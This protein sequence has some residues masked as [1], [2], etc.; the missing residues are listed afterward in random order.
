MKDWFGRKQSSTLKGVAFGL[1]AIGMSTVSIVGIASQGVSK[2]EILI[3]QLGPLTG[4]NFAFGELVMRGNDVIFAEVNAAGGIH[5]RTIR[6]VKAD[7]EC[8]AEAAVGAARRLV[9]ADVLAIVGA[10]CSNATLANMG[11]I[12][13]AG[14]PTVVQGATHDAITNPV[15]CCF[16]RAVMKGSEEGRI[17]ARFV[18]TIPDVRRVAIVAQR[19][20]WG[21]AKYEGFLDEAAGLGLEIVADEEMVRDSTSA[22]AQVARIARANPDVIVTLLFPRPTN[23]FLREAHRQGI[24]DR[25]IIGH[26]SVSDLPQL[27]SDIGSA[28]PL[29]NFYTI[30]LTSYTPDM[31]EAQ[32]L[33]AR[34]KAVHP[35]HAFTQYAMWGIGAAEVLVQ[36]LE[37]A[38]P[39]LDRD[40]VRRAL[41]SAEEFL[42]STFPEPLIFTNEDTDG[43][44]SGMFLRYIDGQVV[45]IGT[46][47]Q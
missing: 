26:T 11:T 19:D 47:F 23:V 22:G 36:A 10:G 13:S 2:N 38:G 44:K 45:R 6:T 12:I 34:F 39:E 7:T 8:R 31:P 32:E 41:L 18:A 1:L 5:G 16:F 33:E 3:G 20:A 42:T 4:E 14:I 15:N 30:S 17:Q 25:P 28:D 46:S 43:N 9:D 21:Q 27:A 40:A 24:T 37:R 35:Q 29:R